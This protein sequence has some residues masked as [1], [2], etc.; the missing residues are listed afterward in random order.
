MGVGPGVSFLSVCRTSWLFVLI[1]HW[2]T[3]FCF[4]TSV[5]QNDSVM[6]T[7]LGHLM[8]RADSLE[9]T[10]ML[11]KIEGGMRR[12]WQRMKCL[13]GITDSMDISLSKLQ[14]TVKDREAWSPAVH[15]VPKSRTWLS[16]RT[17]ATNMYTYIYVHKIFYMGHIFKVFIEF[18]TILLLFYVFLFCC[19]ACGI[20]TP[21]RGIEPKLPSLE[22]KVLTTGLP[23]KSL[24]ILSLYSFPLWFITG[25]WI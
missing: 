23:G 17:T 19:E 15:G 1:E 10:L 5:Q 9:K 20:F 18:V 25:Y 22:G 13:D 2:F 24:Y 7:H 14:E 12:R 16:N 4:V 6:H 11:G 3:V 8:W 21:L